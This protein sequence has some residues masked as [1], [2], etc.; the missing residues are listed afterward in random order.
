MNTSGTQHKRILFLISLPQTPEFANDREEIDECLTELRELKVD[1]REHIRQEDLAAANEYDVVI[2][3]AHYDDDADVL[4]LADSVMPIK[5]FVS[6]LPQDFSGLIDFCSCHSVTAFQAIKNRCPSCL[7][8]VSLK[9]IPLLRRIIIY[10]SVIE[11]F[12]EDESTDYD[13]A[14]EI[15]SKQYDEILGEVSEGRDT[16]PEMTHLGQDMSSVYAPKEVT[17]NDP[18]QI[19]VF[20]HYDWEK[21]VI[22]KQAEIWQSDALIGSNTELPLSLQEGDELTIALKFYTS[23]KEFIVV[24]GGCER[25]ITIKQSERFFEETFV[26]TVLP[27]FP[28]RTFLP[29]IEIQKEGYEIIRSHYFDITVGEQKSNIPAK[30][31]ETSGYEENRETGIKRSWMGP[32]TVLVFEKAIEVGWIIKNEEDFKWI[33]FG[34]LKKNGD[35]KS[36]TRQLAYLCDEAFKLDGLSTPWPYIEEFFKENKQQLRRDLYNVYETSNVPWKNIIDNTISEI[37]NNESAQ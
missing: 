10:P 37:R 15:V 27:E 25:H 8:K 32:K 1:V 14:F 2:V 23:Y 3:V 13:T 11:R 4:V 17:R 31:V 22:K 5:D 28:G 26:V 19:I 21:E 16:E 24:E 6:Y 18:F 36:R 35:Y 30:V 7:A 34:T 20:I 33:G 12:L 29:Y 9:T